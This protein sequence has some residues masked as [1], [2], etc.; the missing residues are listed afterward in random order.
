MDQGAIVQEIINEI[1][2]EGVLEIK[3]ARAKK[4]ETLARKSSKSS[5]S[6]KSKLPR[7]RL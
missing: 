2:S 7:L 6:Y 3:A 5:S 1:V 4:G